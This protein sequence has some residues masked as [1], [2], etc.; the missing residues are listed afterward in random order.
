MVT[1]KNLLCLRNATEHLIAL[2][3][4]L[5]HL[6]IFELIKVRIGLLVDDIVKLYKVFGEYQSI[7]EHKP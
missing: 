5:L 6:S 4:E 1:F 7:V 2:I 3:V